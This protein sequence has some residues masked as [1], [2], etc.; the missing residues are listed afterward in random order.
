MEAEP[1]LTKIA[2][3]KRGA[4]WSILLPDGQEIILIRT[5]AGY[6]RGGHSHNVREVSVLL[7]GSALYLTVN[8]EQIG[9][10]VIEPFIQQAGEVLCN[11]P[12]K[13]HA[14][15]A[16]DDYWLV[17]MRPGSKAADIKSTNDRD[18]RRLIEQQRE[19]PP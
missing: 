19:A 15:L 13:V 17:D 7:S 8:S 4:S 9:S 12:G 10:R 5:N 14:A 1:K 11:P 16:L 3:D 2:E 18:L 6:W